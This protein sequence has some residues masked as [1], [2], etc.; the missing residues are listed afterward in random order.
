MCRIGESDGRRGR[1]RWLTRSRLQVGRQGEFGSG[2]SQHGVGEVLAESRGG[3][4]GEPATIFGESG[5]HG[6][7]CGGEGHEEG[8]DKQE[9]EGFR[10]L[11]SICE[12]C[13]A[14]QCRSVHLKD[15]NPTHFSKA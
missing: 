8:A 9:D 10:V 12:L 14:C 13:V 4:Q 6:M 3:G 1:W 7:I 5:C 2:R 15:R 11:L